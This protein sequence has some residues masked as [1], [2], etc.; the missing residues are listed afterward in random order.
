[1]VKKIR[2][3]KYFR[4]WYYLF[5]IESEDKLL[6][7]KWKIALEEKDYVLTYEQALDMI[8]QNLISNAINYSLLLTPVL[9]EIRKDAY[10]DLLIVCTNFGIEIPEEEINNG[11]I[12]KISYAFRG[13]S[14]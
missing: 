8:I 1:M 7:L 6:Y 4:D 2:L 9:I 12:W 3:K 5:K 14:L 10:G 13:L 11:N